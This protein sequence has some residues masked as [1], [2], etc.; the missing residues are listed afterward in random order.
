MRIAFCAAALIGLLSYE[1]TA[2]SLESVDFD[3]ADYDTELAEIDGDDYDYDLAQ[4]EDEDWDYDFAQIDEEED[5]MA[6]IDSEVDS[7]VDS[8]AESDSEIDSDADGEVDADACEE[9]VNGIV[10][11]LDKPGCPEEEKKVPFEQAMLGA[12]GE[13]STKSNELAKAL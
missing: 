6:E 8:D 5:D 10:I 7:E 9:M 13:L 2:A 12:L 11:K 1:A 4:I 3:L